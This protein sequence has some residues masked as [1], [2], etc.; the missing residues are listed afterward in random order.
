M[1]V[2]VPNLTSQQQQQHLRQLQL[3]QQ[4]G[5]NG[6]GVKKKRKKLADYE[7]K[8][9]KFKRDVMKKIREIEYLTIAN[10]YPYHPHYREHQNQSPT[11]KGS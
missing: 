11:V 1:R 4:H 7:K 6:G 9:L 8:L 5:L 10:D 2:K 3:Q